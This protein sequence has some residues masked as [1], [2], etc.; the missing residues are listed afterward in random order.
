MCN[1]GQIIKSTDESVAND[2]MRRVNFYNRAPLS[3]QGSI[4]DQYMF[5]HILRPHKRTT[6]YRVCQLLVPLGWV[7]FDFECSTVSTILPR[8]M[9]PW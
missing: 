6:L 1:C 7:Y 9:G 5:V 4:K 2:F 3:M 8:L